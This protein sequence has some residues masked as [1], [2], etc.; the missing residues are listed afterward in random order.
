MGGGVGICVRNDI[1][2]NIAAHISERNLEIM[3][4]SIRRKKMPPLF[5]G[6]YYGK[7]ETRTNK[8]EIE[9]EMTLLNEEIEEIQK[10]GEILLTMDGNAKI[11]LL[12]EEIS[13]N[14]KEILK[15]LRNTNLKILNGSEKCQGNIT[16][17]NTKKENEVSAIDF[18]WASDNVYRWID[19]VNIDEEGLL[20]I[21]GKNNTDHNTICIN[22]NVP[23][24]EKT[25]TINRT[26]WN[27]KADDQKWKAFSNELNKRRE[28]ATRKITNSEED[29]DKRYKKWFNEIDSAA[30]KT[31]GKTTFKE[32]KKAKVTKDLNELQQQK[33]NLKN[34]IQ[35]EKDKEKKKNL[36]ISYKEIQEQILKQMTSEKANDIKEKL[37]KIATDG[38]RNALWKEKRIMTRNPT[39]ES[40]IVKNDEGKRLYNPIEIK[41]Q[42]A[43]YYETLYKEKPHDPHPY[44]QEIKRKMRK[45]TEDAQYEN[46]RY[47][48]TPTRQEIGDII[49]KKKNNKSTPDIKNEMLKRTG[50]P[51]IEIVYPLIKT[52]WAEENIPKQW[53]KGNITSIWKG[54]GD[55]E[56]LSNHR[57]ITTSSA[58]GTILDTM[59][60]NRIE[61]LVKFTQAQGGGRKGASC[62]DHLFILRAIMDLSISAKQSTFVTFYDVSKAYDNVDNQDMLV[63]IWEKGLKGKAW[64]ILKNLNSNLT[65]SIKTRFGQTREIQMEIGGKQGSRLTGRM[66]SKLMDLISEELGETELGFILS[67]ELTIP[68]LLWVDDVVTCT[69]GK[70]KQKQVLQ[71]VAD[72]ATKHKLKWGREKCNVMRVGK[73]NDEEQE[74]QLGNMTIKET[75]KYKYLG[76]VITTDG[77]NTEN[78]QSRKTKIQATTITINTIASS[79]I[80]NKIE[81]SVLLELHEKISIA[82]LLNN[83]ESWNLSKGEED[84]LEKIEIQAIKS[85]FDLPLHTPTAAIIYTLGILYTTQRVD[86]KQLMFLQKILQRKNDDWTR[87]TLKALTLK[88][89]GW[90]RRIRNILRKYKLPLDFETI[91]SYTPD[92]WR[93]TTTLAIEEINKTRLRADLNKN[94]NGTLIPKTKTKTI[95]D[96]LSAP[97]YTRKPE[98]EIIQTTKNETKTCIIARYGMLECGVNYKGTMKPTCDTCNTIDNEE[99]RMNDC[100]KWKSNDT[101]GKVT[102]NDIYSN[103]INIVRSVIT[104][105]ET[106]WNTK[107]AHGT[108]R[109]E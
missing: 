41:E 86:Q 25:K 53:N 33:R 78:L 29:I 38:D 100:I 104:R 58:I 67:E 107:N 75:A 84:E 101:N 74:W 12:G 50:E 102:F 26:G 94:E 40:L 62:C 8:N 1:R 37:E 90:Y 68:S 28:T 76:D 103:D 17:Q 23:N 98:S 63:T 32:S 55:K 99:H 18:V 57:G 31:I 2:P 81:T 19:K 82:G 85:L 108:M 65:A 71:K 106:V 48:K 52:I 36:I 9:R 34:E 51:I 43:H 56:D 27:L 73:H 96:K 80:L 54:K 44:H 11:G 64:R 39:L 72:F 97:D 83:A 59:I 35:D 77:K 46:L 109:T 10:E 30:R 91:E 87:N 4:V 66:F 6:T 5:V 92:S 20:K 22:L 14:G 42:T 21:R 60:D 3:W 49:T 95:I 16:R 45:Y 89:I 88:G 69:E 105:I 13:R 70:E 7:Q 47:N 15:V 93:D 61:H 79:E 24:V